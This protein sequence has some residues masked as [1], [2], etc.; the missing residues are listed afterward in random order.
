M[1]SFVTRA[2]KK[3]MLSTSEQGKDVSILVVGEK[4][5][6]QLARVHGD[7]SVLLA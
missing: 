7:V 3:I 1:N 2:I 4:G 5:R 6:S